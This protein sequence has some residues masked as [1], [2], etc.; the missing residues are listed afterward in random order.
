MTNMSRDFVRPQKGSLEEWA[1]FSEVGDGLAVGRISREWFPEVSGLVRA[2]IFNDTAAPEVLETVQNHNSDSFWGM[3]RKAAASHE[4]VGVYGQLLLNPQGH[5]ALLRGTLDRLNPSLDLLVQFRER[6]S[7]VYIWCVVAKKR[8]AMLQAALVK[9]LQDQ[10][11]MPYYAVLATPDSFR[12]GKHIGFQPVAASDD[13]IGGLFKLP[14]R[15]PMLRPSVVVQ[16]K[17]VVKTV[18][19]AEE[20]SHVLALRA[21]TFVAEQDCPIIEEFDGNDFSAQHLIAYLDGMPAAA[22]RIRH[23]ASFVKWERLCVLA[24]FR[25]TAVSDELLGFATEI[26]QQKGFTQIYFQAEAALQVF[27]ERRGFTRISKRTVQFSGREYLEFAKNISVPPTVLDLDTD[28][29]ILNRVE[30]RWH[31]PGVLDRS[32]ERTAA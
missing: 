16:R 9:Q 13:R 30:G 11:G 19:T 7:A 27:W 8:G 18:E 5:E 29:M 23:F 22:I 12:A 15:L 20:F 14:D 10:H 2:R 21:A 25:K 4:L 31:Q 28:P 1:T 3:F 24:C 26:A 17:V 32:A 6:P